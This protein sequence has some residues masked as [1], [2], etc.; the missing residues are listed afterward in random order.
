M[1]YLLKKKLLSSWDK[2]AFDLLIRDKLK[3]RCLFD[4]GA[5]TPVFTLGDDA[6]CKYFPDAQL[7]KELTYILSGF[8]KGS[9]E[10]SV[11]KIPEFIIRSDFDDDC[12]LFH[13]LYI[14]SCFK[15]AIAY[16]FILSATMFSHMNYTI[17][18]EGKEA[19]CIE[20]QHSKPVYN[21]GMVNSRLDNTKLTKIYS[22]VENGCDK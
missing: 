6:L 17:I 2:P 20:I 7:Q 21:I 18:N 1:G 3:I 14:A 19:K 16:P 15:P 4:T 11:Y 8:G 5:D 12:I 9:E 13:N 10:A 22:F